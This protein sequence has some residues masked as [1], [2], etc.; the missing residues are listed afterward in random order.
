[1]AD[2][3]EHITLNVEGMTCSNC[4]L[5]ITRTLAKHGLSNVD[6][7]FSTGEV[8]FDIIEGKDK[9]DEAV[10]TINK[11]GYKVIEKKETDK[12][13]LSLIEKK[14]YFSLIFTVPLFFSHMILSHNH[15]LNDPWVQLVLCIP[16]F[17]L[18][19]LH[20]GKSAWGSLKA[21]IP[22][23]DVL[24][25]IG[26]SAAF[27]YSLAGTIMYFGTHQVHDYI[28]YETAG[29]II[30]LVLLGSVMEYKSVKQTTTAINE[31]SK[32]QVLTAKKIT[33]KNEK[34]QINEIAYHEINRD[35]VLMVN[36]GD[37]IPVDGQV[38]S[39]TASVDESMITGESFPVDKQK[40]SLV[41]GGTIL[42]NGNI[43]MVAQKVGRETMLSQIIELVKNAQL[44][45]PAIQK[46]GDKISAVFV[47]IVVLIALATFFIWFFIVG[48]TLSTALMTSIAVLVISCP[49]AMGLATPTAVMVGIGRAAKNGILIKGGSTLEEISKIK[50]VVFDKT[51]TLTTGNFSIKKI[52]PIE[53]AN[54][55]EILNLLYSLEIH[56]SHPIAR[57]VVESL[58]SKANVIDFK[59]VSELKGMGIKATDFTGNNYFLGGAHAIPHLGEDE[60]YNLYL[61]KND[62]LIAAVD[63]ED[64][65]K[66][67]AALLIQTLKE[68]NI[69][70]VLLSGDKKEKCESLAKTL[71]IEKVYSEQLPQQKLDIIDELM[72]T[73]YVAMVGDGV[74]DAPALAKATVGISLG[75]ATQVAI[76]SAQVILLKGNDLM[77][78]DKALNVGKHSV[79]TIKQNLFWAFFYNILA[80]P[81]AAMGF[82]SPVIAALAMAFSDVIVVGNSIRLKSKKI[83]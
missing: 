6:T 63:I 75:N 57:S 64:E 32:M 74:N 9:L 56:S 22:N 27:L 29:M 55:N 66:Q 54:E 17:I 37:K 49:C 67:N 23:M 21:G 15:F 45:R 28:F 72:K 47:P 26:T 1:M 43:R 81:I 5:S 48:V 14:L 38:I 41:I 24:I 68:K 70:T 59:E 60:N 52:I 79:I 33:R 77:L 80:I 20:F 44:K 78:V 10:N 34:E 83:F 31:L 73:G 62:K 16:V 51:G 18:G 40:D 65:I 12:K 3:N 76:Q 46:L 8:T 30:S 36:T 39:G 69:Q 71:G 61:T 50:T 7:N 53:D 4:A 11:L 2:K 82:L 58:K 25:V 42:V 35:D 19:V 13:G